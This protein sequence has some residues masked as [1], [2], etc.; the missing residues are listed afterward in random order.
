[1]SDLDIFAESMWLYLTQASS[2]LGKCWKS[3]EDLVKATGLGMTKVRKALDDLEDAGM[4]EV[5]RGKWYMEIRIIGFQTDDNTVD[6]ANDWTE[7]SF[8]EKAILNRP[9]LSWRARGLGVYILANPGRRVREVIE[10][11]TDD[12]EDVILALKELR[13]CGLVDIRDAPKE[14]DK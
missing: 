14:V 3:E 13:D 4:I 12:V 7:A 11:G 8:A 10:H 9:G 2:Y 1:M 6:A 5:E